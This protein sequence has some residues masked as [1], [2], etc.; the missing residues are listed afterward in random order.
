MSCTV[1][2]ADDII[3]LRCTDSEGSLPI[4][5][6]VVCYN[7]TTSGS[8]AYYICNGDYQVPGYSD[9]KHKC[10]L[11]E[12]QGDGHWS[13]E[14]IPCLNG[15]INYKDFVQLVTCALFSVEMCSDSCN[16]GISLCFIFSLGAGAITILIVAFV[17]RWHILKQKLSRTATDS[18]S[19]SPCHT[20]NANEL[21]N[22]VEYSEDIT[23]IDE[24]CGT[25]DAANTVE[26]KNSTN[27]S[28]ELLEQT[29]Q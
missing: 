14:T 28:N 16:I 3:D 22:Y 6:G 19:E 1:D 25:S 17:V 23:D 5:N 27:T 7:G 8:T 2:M 11:R 4:L 18:I 21:P 15:S 13:G 24:T 10:N 12:C 20:N 26:N 29:Q 9:C